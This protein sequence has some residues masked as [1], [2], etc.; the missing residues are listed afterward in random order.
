MIALSEVNS[1]QGNQLGPRPTSKYMHMKFPSTIP[2]PLICPLFVCTSHT[3]IIYLT[4]AILW[5]EF[6]CMYVSPL[7]QRPNWIKKM[8]KKRKSIQAIA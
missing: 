4:G 3:H 8:K 1:E 7:Q 5:E 2:K 6:V